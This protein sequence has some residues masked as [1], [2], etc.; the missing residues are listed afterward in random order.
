MH[1]T[2]ALLIV[3]V[4]SAFSAPFSYSTDF[5]FKSWLT[6]EVQVPEPGSRPCQAEVSVYIVKSA[7][8][9]HSSTVLSITAGRDSSGS[10][11][12]A[13]Q[14]RFA[15]V[16][17]YWKRAERAI[18]AGKSLCVEALL[19]FFS[20]ESALVLVLAEGDTLLRE[21]GR[22]YT[23]R[24]MFVVNTTEDE[25]VLLNGFLVTDDRHY[26]TPAT[27]GSLSVGWKN[28]RPVLCTD[29]FVTGYP[30]GGLATTRWRL[31]RG[32]D[33][34]HPFM[35]DL[36]EDPA[37]F[38]ANPLSFFP[39]KG[40]YRF[41]AARRNHAGNWS[42][43]SP[44]FAFTADSGVPPMPQID[45]IFFS[46]RPGGKALPAIRAG[47]WYWLN[48]R[49]K[50]WVAFRNADYLIA[51]FHDS[52][53]PFGH[54]GNKGGRYFRDRNYVYNMSFTGGPM[55]WLFQKTQ[56]SSYRS[57]KIP[58]GQCGLYL[59]AGPDRVTIDSA[60]RLF[61]MRVRVLPEARPG[62]WMLKGFFVGGRD[63]FFVKGADYVSEIRE[64]P[65][66]LLPAAGGAEKRLFWLLL[67]PAVAAAVFLLKRRRRPV[68]ETQNLPLERN[69]ILL[70]DYINANIS[71]AEISA[72]KIREDLKFSRS[73]YY[74]IL[75]ARSI[76]NL[77]NL[78]NSLKV[79][80]AQELLKS[81]SKNIT[82][83]A[84][85]VGFSD[86]SYFSKIFKAYTGQN[87]SD[88]RQ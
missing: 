87:P 14:T 45:T 74:E 57:D 11:F 77:P 68:P 19:D 69:W 3:C 28:G 60:Q 43:W 21:R 9:H 72:A 76:S 80:R 63:T 5:R 16:Q 44:G 86:T 66:E 7:R 58:E 84:F 37:Y 64:I 40:E 15:A 36:A 34:L 50:D 12:I 83:I 24:E 4:V 35:D 27:P 29:T 6:F 88:Y 39:P 2:L 13:A 38:F 67:L 22:C 70:L 30:N 26:A 73:Q 47:L 42:A 79:K 82:E 54:P 17:E 61:R 78:V 48:V 49:I 32:E 1:T 59:D 51:Q 56:D 81:T 75:K 31:F 71:V 85:E 62:P 23:A 46:S 10:P 18:P 52:V 8:P 25:G 53:Y 20:P 65:V 55:P 33:T 41:R